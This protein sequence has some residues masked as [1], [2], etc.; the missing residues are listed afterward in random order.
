MS[1]S[2]II[3]TPPD[4]IPDYELAH[5]LNHNFT[6]L[7]QFVADPSQVFEGIDLEVENILAGNGQDFRLE[8]ADTYV[9][10][11][12]KNIDLAGG[13]IGAYATTLVTGLLM[14][15]NGIAMGYHRK[16]DGNWVNAVAISSTG[17]VTILGTLT[18]G[19]VIA[20]TVTVDA[21]P[22]ID[23]KTNAEIGAAHAYDTGGNPHNTPLS[24]ISGDLDDIA[25]GSTYFRVNAT[26]H[27]SNTT[28]FWYKGAISTQQIAVSGTN[29]TNGLVIDSAGIRGYK[30]SSLTFSINAS[31]GV[32]TWSG[33]ISTSGSIFADGSTTDPLG[34]DLGVIVANPT[35]TSVSGFKSK[36]TGSISAAN[37]INSGGGYAL[38]AT[39]ESGSSGSLAAILA[40][41]GRS[42]NPG[43]TVYNTAGGAAI[44][45]ASPVIAGDADFQDDVTIVGGLDITGTANLTVDRTGIFAQDE[46]SGNSS[47]IVGN[48]SATGTNTLIIAEGAAG[49]NV[50]GQMHIYGHNDGGETAFGIVQERAVAAYS[51]WAI[52]SS[53]IIYHNGT[54]YYVPL[55]LVA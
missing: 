52:N 38:I 3:I 43:I 39:K 4:V 24:T 21:V 27:L 25:D 10:A 20:T 29:P 23:V 14:N 6:V 11:Y 34:G 16:S 36:T 19:S 41:S 18:A 5:I 54:K 15:A 42:G 13:S 17:N 28:P 35:S 7:N 50:A 37:F 55:S 48:K 53:W 40:L 1:F 32:S 26:N 45:M 47:V 49:S 51:A 8:V 22:I 2:E 12:H 44:N 9:A 31:T 33:D 46:T 30:S